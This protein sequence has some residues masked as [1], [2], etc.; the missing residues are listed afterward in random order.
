[1]DRG[2]D[3]LTITTA[4]ERTAIG[5]RIKNTANNYYWIALNDRD[6]RN[7]YYWSNG[8]ANALISWGS[9]APDNS[10]RTS[11]TNLFLLY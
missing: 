9:G 8:D 6:Y 2:G 11:M 7:D 10:G 1:M 3:L 5:E 4:K